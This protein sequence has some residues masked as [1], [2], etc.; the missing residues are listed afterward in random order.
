MN[1]HTLSTLVL[2]YIPLHRR[3]DLY[4]LL[5][6][7]K[8]FHTAAEPLVYHNAVFYDV[9]RLICFLHTLSR[10]PRL[11]G[12]VHTFGINFGD[13]RPRVQS[14]TRQLALNSQ[15]ETILRRSFWNLVNRAMSTM[16][17]LQ[18]LILI[19]I[20]D[21]R[22]NFTWILD[23]QTQEEELPFAL[24]EIELNLAFDN[25]VAK[26]LNAQGEKGRLRVVRLRHMD[27][28]GTSDLLLR[29]DP[30]A[31]E[32]IG[33][34]GAIEDIRLPDVEILDMSLS[35]APHLGSLGRSLTNLQIHVDVQIPEAGI[36]V[37]TLVHLISPANSRVVRG[38]SL[39][40]LPAS[41]STSVFTQIANSPVLSN[42]TTT[43]QHLS[44]FHLPAPYSPQPPSRSPVQTSNS[45]FL[46]HYLN[47]ELP[48]SCGEPSPIPEKLEFL[49]TLTHFHSLRSLE[50]SLSSWDFFDS[51]FTTIQNFNYISVNP[52]YPHPHHFRPSSFS[53]SSVGGGGGPGGIAANSVPSPTTQKILLG[54]LKAHCPSLRLVVLWLNRIKFRWTYKSYRAADLNVGIEEMEVLYGSM[55]PI[56]ETDGSLI[57][58]WEDGEFGVAK[59]QGGVGAGAG[60]GS[61]RKNTS[62]VVEDASMVQVNCG[63][64][65][66]SNKVIPGEWFCRMDMNQ[67][68]SLSSLWISC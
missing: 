7:S 13:L 36:L 24:K 43:L 10:T 31:D 6:T 56:W 5:L 58:S 26:F 68:A 21:L 64:P 67:L 47:D 18:T 8:S 49:H 41:I 63:P 14:Y 1:Q 28:P 38:L 48:T 23:E 55:K 16:T 12:L 40:D 32:D 50:L 30:T 19:Q 52:Q 27:V 2:S 37:D 11:A 42:L 60:G 17:S 61:G 4:S 34:S 44:H 9:R 29:C 57:S 45:S 59:G 33:G 25:H 53:I 62:G 15:L 54:E 46:P 51:S 22:M 3:R 65:V 35:I 39:V 66:L 20:P